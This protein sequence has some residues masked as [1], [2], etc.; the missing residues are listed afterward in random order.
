MQL[1]LG[2]A[3]ASRAANG[4][5]PLALPPSGGSLL[6]VVFPDEGAFAAGRRELHAGARVLPN[7]NCI[8]PA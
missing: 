4:A 7:S 2:S 8:V 6:M 5:A 3:R 1:V